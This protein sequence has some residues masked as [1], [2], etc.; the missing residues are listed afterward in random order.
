MPRGSQHFP[1][2]KLCCVDV[3]AGSETAL[4]GGDGQVE[5]TLISNNVP[6]CAL[7]VSMEM[8][9][10]ENAAVHRQCSAV[11]SDFL[12]GHEGIKYFVKSLA[13]SSSKACVHVSSA[14]I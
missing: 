4:A 14:V 3:S 9:M 6:L 10:T 13:E 5:V 2:C 11:M 1:V 7:R 8:L 12:R